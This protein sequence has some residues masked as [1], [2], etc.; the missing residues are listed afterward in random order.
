MKL[1]KI[2]GWTGDEVSLGN[3]IFVDTTET[4]FSC[5]QCA[6]VDTFTIA[7]MMPNKDPICQE[8]FTSRGNAHSDTIKRVDE[9]IT[10]AE[11]IA[12]HDHA[13]I[14]RLIK[15]AESELEA[16]TTIIDKSNTEISQL[17]KEHADKI[18]KIRVANTDLNRVALAHAIASGK[19]RPLVFNTYGAFMA[20]DERATC[21]NCHRGP[22]SGF[23]IAYGD[24][25]RCDCCESN[26]PE[27]KLV[28]AL[29][30]RARKQ[31]F[32]PAYF[33]EILR[34]LHAVIPNSTDKLGRI[35][36]RIQ[37]CKGAKLAAMAD[38]SSIRHKLSHLRLVLVM[39]MNI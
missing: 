36:E 18:R 11:F 6:V 32:T 19:S 14:H 5:A 37:E 9:M 16:F 3:L 17:E 4:A 1:A 24:R 35:A 28:T 15:D 2:F 29:M 39:T 21:G 22:G 25:Y 7:F 30:Q 27:W 12:H 8:C 20:D 33:E 34:K 23:I 26:T 10:T 31:K 13:V 38:S